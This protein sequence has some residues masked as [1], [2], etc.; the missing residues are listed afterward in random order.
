MLSVHTFRHSPRPGTPAAELSQRVPEPVARRRSAEVR[1]AA[2]TAGQG[3][4]DRAVGRRER[5]VWDRV[6]QGLA[7]GLSATY[8]EVVSEAGPRTRPGTACEVELLAVE[9]GTLRARLLAP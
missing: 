8:L 3:R 5:V 6:D 9:G 2:T 4:R 1:R 7:H